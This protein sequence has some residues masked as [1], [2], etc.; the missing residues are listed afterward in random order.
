MQG[1]SVGALHRL[2]EGPTRQGSTV[3]TRV[4]ASRA[5]F[6]GICEAGWVNR[7]ITQSRDVG[8]AGH[9]VA[10]KAGWETREGMDF[11][12]AASDQGQEKRGPSPEPR[13]QEKRA[14]WNTQKGLI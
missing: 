4:A 8:G 6:L 2:P 7:G 11:Q 13:C 3:D 1:N 10:N 5:G 14:A 9:M 12:R